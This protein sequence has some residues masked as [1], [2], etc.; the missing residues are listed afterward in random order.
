MDPA[1]GG[2]GGRHKINA[3]V[4]GV[5]L[6]PTGTS[7]LGVAGCP[8]RISFFD[9]RV[10][11]DYCDIMTSLPRPA[12]TPKWPL[13]ATF[14]WRRWRGEVGRQMGAIMQR[15]THARPSRP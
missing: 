10:S 4:V 11:R 13:R 5:R 14:A 7:Q 9:S 1:R 8:A 3:L 6:S 12:I 15:Q 2:E